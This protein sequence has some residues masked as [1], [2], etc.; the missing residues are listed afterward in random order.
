MKPQLGLFI[1]GNDTDVGKTYVTS[2]IAKSLVAAGHRVGVYKP[3]ASGCSRVDGQLRADDAVAIWEA[4]GRPRSLTD[5]C[6][7]AFEAPLAPQLAARAEGR[8]IDED[9]LFKGIEVWGDDCDILLVEGVGG[10]MSPVT[11]NLYVADIAREIGYPLVVVAA[12]RIGVINQTLQTLI[13][14]ATFRDGLNTAG[15]IL[16]DVQKPTSTDPS[17]TSNRDQIE[18]HCVPPLLSHVNYNDDRIDA[19]IDWMAIA[20]AE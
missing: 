8:D 14:A 3:V 9:L 1:A 19:D 17:S 13:T 18:L 4:A 16:N 11:D 12:N 6:P 15:I 2:L 10:L 7:Q 5:V 20:K